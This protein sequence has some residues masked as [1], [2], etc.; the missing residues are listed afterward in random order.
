[1]DSEDIH[2]VNTLLI[3]STVMFILHEITGLSDN[4]LSY[5]FVTAMISLPFLITLIVLTEFKHIYLDSMNGVSLIL[6]C[7]FIF[8]FLFFAFASISF[9]DQTKENLKIYGLIYSLIVF[10]LVPSLTLSES[11]NCLKENKFIYMFLTLICHIGFFCFYL[12]ASRM[13]V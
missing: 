11:D 2:V 3:T 12:F 13:P 10:F 6:F 1:M 4:L 9:P 7:F 5:I 8:F